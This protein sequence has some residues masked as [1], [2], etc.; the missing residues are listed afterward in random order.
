M[1]ST[2]GPNSEGM[3]MRSAQSSNPK[4]R[5]KGLTLIELML[6]LFVLAVGLAGGMILVSTA[7]ATNNRNKLDTTATLIAQTVLE[8]ILQQ[9]ASSTAVIA[10]TDCT[11]NQLNIN[12]TSAAA[13]GAGSPVANGSLTFQ[14][15]PTAGYGGT[16]TV[17][18][19][20]GMTATYDVQWNI[21]TMGTS[22]TQVYTKYVT[23]A[24]RP[25]GAA[26]NNKSQILFYGVPISL[27]GMA[28]D[29]PN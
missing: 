22:G 21:T 1:A 10:I 11:G 7:I 2:T 24:A 3:I 27:R 17:C 28:A 26:A 6:A 12:N 18:R 19:A 5:Q 9:G 20:G 25:Q 29:S 13:P 15:A 23:V 4:R 16:Y 14:A 8:R